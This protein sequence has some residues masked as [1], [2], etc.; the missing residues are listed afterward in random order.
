MKPEYPGV[1]GYIF[2]GVKQN[3]R[4]NVRNSVSNLAEEHMEEVRS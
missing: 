2:T 4:E 3:Y 1:S